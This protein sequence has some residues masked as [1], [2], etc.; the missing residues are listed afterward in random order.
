M[1]LEVEK[2]NH[3][4]LNKKKSF[5]PTV[6]TNETLIKTFDFA[7]AMV[8]GEGYHR[9]QRS[10]G[11]KER[12]KGEL[13]ANTFQ[14]KLAE[15]IIHSEL[16]KN[17]ITNIEEPDVSVHG[18]GIWDDSDLAYK[19]KKINIK[20]AAFFSNLLLL[21]SKDWNKKGEYIPNLKNSS[22]QE[23]DYFILVR[24]KPD[25][26]QVFK[27]EKILYSDEIRMD[28]LKEV[29]H[30]ANWY[31]DFAGVCSD[32][33][34][35]YSIQNNYFLPQNSLLNGTIKMDAANYYI[36]AGDLKGFSFFID[37]LKKI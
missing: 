28:T 5:K 21:E 37:E 36:Q 20:S 17:N 6:V 23:Y 11:N 25:I 15:F 26:K 22:S 18:K 27:K 29:I 34:I 30:N 35:K 8:F 7:Y 31:Y 14:G 13:F 16:K 12:K 24:V 1:K 32:K 4:F 19:G 2:G 10:G 3:F 33:T 9:N